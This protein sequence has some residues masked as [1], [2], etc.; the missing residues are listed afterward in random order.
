MFICNF[1]LIFLLCFPQILILA[2]TRE[3]AVQIK[4]VVC[5]IGRHLEGL[6]VHV[7][8]GGMPIEEDKRH[9][10]QCHIAVGT[11]GNNDINLY[12]GEKERGSL[13]EKE[14]DLEFCIKQ[15]SGKFLLWFS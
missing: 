14:A 4:D 8:I 12:I 10:K 15:E 11:P 9:L 13:R 6:C 5:S 1:F 2:P 7:F 3:I